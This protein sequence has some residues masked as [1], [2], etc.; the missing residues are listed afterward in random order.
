M[1]VAGLLLPE[2]SLKGTPFC[3]PQDSA[4]GGPTPQRLRGGDGSCHLSSANPQLSAPH[5]DWVCPAAT[6]LALSLTGH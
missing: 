5:Q 2:F 1:P 3:C 6:A 4:G